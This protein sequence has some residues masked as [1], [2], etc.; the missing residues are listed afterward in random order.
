MKISIHFNKKIPF[1][2]SKGIFFIRCF[3]I[4]EQFAVSDSVNR[5]VQ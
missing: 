4:I 1:E 2:K 3:L 5:F